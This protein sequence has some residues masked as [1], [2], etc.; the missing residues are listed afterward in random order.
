MLYQNNQ[1]QIN[2]MKKI[3]LVCL[4]ATSLVGLYSCNSNN[5]AVEP[6]DDEM[7][8]ARV[9]AQAAGQ[10]SD[11]RLTKV[12]V[13]D[14]PAAVTAYIAKN[15]VG[16]TA[17][18]AGKDSAGNL[19]VI[20][21][22]N[23]TLKALQFGADGAFKQELAFMGGRG[24]DHNGPGGPHERG[25]KSFTA[26]DV[27]ALPA[28]IT[29]YVTS[30]YASSTISGAAQNAE[31][32]Y[33]VFVKTTSG[34]V[35][36]EFNADGSFKQEIVRPGKGRGSFTDITAAELPKT[37]TDYITK[38]YA[39]STI[40]KA[41]KSSVDGGFLVWI[42]K[43]DGTNVGLSFGADGAFKQEMTCKKDNKP[44]T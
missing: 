25:P 14:L 42:K 20:I 13:K 16:F 43:A 4:M 36:L 26:I 18:K 6:E 35:L 15:Y 9:G 38:T 39:G 32:L 21:K 17:D 29:S 10:T 41:A 5:S 24:K 34:K 27:A 7:G 44:T 23:N 1:N 28:K 30:K 40:N 31:K 3:L 37:V 22:Q 8:Q 11:R 33:V 2:S 19:T 12:E